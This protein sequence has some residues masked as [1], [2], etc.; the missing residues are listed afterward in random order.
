MSA[1]VNVS[2]LECVT[3]EGLHIGRLGVVERFEGDEDSSSPCMTRE[4]RLSR[5]AGPGV[6]DLGVVGAVLREADVGA[7]TADAVG[8]ITRTS[9]SPSTS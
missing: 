3:T 1:N 9:A 7:G 8:S 2:R 5:P 6:A 4:R